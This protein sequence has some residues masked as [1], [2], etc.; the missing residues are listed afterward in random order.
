MARWKDGP[1]LVSILCP[2]YQHVDFVEDALRG[3]LGQDTD[4]PFEVIV[5]DDAS[6]DGTAEIVREYAMRFPNIVQPILEATNAYPA[7]RPISVLRAAARGEFVAICEG[8]DYWFS[9]DFLQRHVD[10]LRGR[11]DIAVSVSVGIPIQDGR[12]LGPPGGP[13]WDELS[14]W[15]LRRAG[16]IGIREMCF[17]ASGIE[18][19]RSEGRIPGLD[20]FLLNRQG[21]YGGATRMSDL[22]R[23]AFRV[24]PG[25]VWSS[26]TDEERAVLHATTHYWIGVFFDESGDRSAAEHH[27]AQASEILQ[28]SRLTRGVDPRPMLLWRLLRAVPGMVR[29]RLVRVAARI[30]RR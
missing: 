30:R 19:W 22:V 9:P 23:T 8:D 28:R 5:R 14:P 2:T 26:R 21:L 25:G 27:L 24:H 20:L 18:P 11:P 10:A 12:V 1:P 3:F 7:V 29:R 13:M 16:A 6:I 17:R 4:F 15:E